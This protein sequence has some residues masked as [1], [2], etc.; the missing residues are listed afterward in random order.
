MAIVRLT[1]GGDW[2]EQSAQLVFGRLFL[3]CL[4]YFMSC[5]RSSVIYSTS[6]M[7]KDRKSQPDRPALPAAKGT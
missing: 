6:F 4:H 3:K 7:R 5:L 2:A 1:E